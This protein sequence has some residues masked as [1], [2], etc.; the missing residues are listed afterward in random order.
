MGVRSLS[1]DYVS[2]MTSLMK[3]NRDDD[4]KVNRMNGQE[5]RLMGRRVGRERSCFLLRIDGL[6]FLLY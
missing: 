4:V 3:V 1:I 6:E 2:L 5:R